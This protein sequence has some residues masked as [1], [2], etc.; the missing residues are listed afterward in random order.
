VSP[1]HSPP[2]WAPPSAGDGALRAAH[3][4]RSGK[5]MAAPPCTLSRCSPTVC[6]PCT[7]PFVAAP[8]G[9]LTVSGARG[10]QRSRRRQPSFLCGFAGRIAEC[11]AAREEGQRT[12]GHQK[13]GETA[14]NSCELGSVTLPPA[15]A[16]ATGAIEAT[17]DRRA[18]RWLLRSSKTATLSNKKKKKWD[19]V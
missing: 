14:L 10:E 5:W 18:G 4:W 7:V 8:V 19:Q 13:G 9:S 17:R 1:A 12:C 6:V 2:R 11:A 3:R 16:S 15:N